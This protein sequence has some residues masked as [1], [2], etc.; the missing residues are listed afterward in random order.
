MSH[1]PMPDAD[2]RLFDEI[3]AASRGGDVRSIPWAHGKPNPFL[4]TWLEHAPAPPEGR[5]RA[6]VIAAGLG[7]DAEALSTRGWRVT[8]FDTSAI[9]IAWARERFAESVVDYHVADLFAMPPEWIGAFDLVV[10]V[11]TIQALPPTRRQ[12]TID[13]I[14]ST[15]AVGGTLFVVTFLRDVHAVAN[16]RPWPLTKQE[17]ASIARHQMQEISRHTAK[18][19]PERLNLIFERK[20]FIS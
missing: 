3:Y 12:E 16:G 5:E 19:R 2:A 13:R 14:A 8:A 1:T 10:E 18:D 4:A 15:V 11:H 9:A 7:D 17:V 20:A 6:L